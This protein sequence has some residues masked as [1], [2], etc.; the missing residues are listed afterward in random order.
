MAGTKTEEF[1][2]GR[3]SYRLVDTP[4]SLE[5][6]RTT[7]YIPPPPLEKLK[8]HLEDV[9]SEARGEGFMMVAMILS[10]LAA[11]YGDEVYDAIEPVMYDYGR[12]RAEE[13]GRI[14]N[15]DPKDARSA[16]RIFD[17]ED[18]QNGIKGE[19]VESGRQRAVKREYF[20]PLSTAASMCPE[21]C[22][23]IAAAVERGTFDGLGIKGNIT[24]PKLIP[25][26]D[27]YCEIVIELDE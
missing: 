4:Q 13:F 10:V 8:L 23:R 19:W 7:I 18:S 22:T 21:F 5:E 27:P 26:G 11:K 20:C 12:G 3:Y 14:M 6:D 17:L 15:I 9:I 16:G 24:F 1:E 25:K 2:H